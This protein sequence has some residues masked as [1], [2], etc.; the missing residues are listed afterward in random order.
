MSLK[1]FYNNVRRAAKFLPQRWISEMPRLT[2]EPIEEGLRSDRNWLNRKLVAGYS[3]SDFA[4]LP[5]TQGTPEW[6]PWPGGIFREFA[7]A[8]FPETGG[9]GRML[10]NQRPLTVAAP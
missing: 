4:F 6:R 7:V 9:R 2:I 1:E 3:E 5:E 10:A 8:N